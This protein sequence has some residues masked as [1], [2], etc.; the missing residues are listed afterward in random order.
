MSCYRCV[1]YK[2]NFA[3]IVSISA[4]MRS[5]VWLKFRYICK[6]RLLC[7]TH[8]AIHLEVPEYLVKSIIIQSYNISSRKFYIMKLVQRSIY[9]V[10]S[11]STVLVVAS[12]IC[13]SLPYDIR[14]TTSLSLF[15]R[16]LYVNF[17]SL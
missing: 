6:H 12:K 11:K 8:K 3:S 9:L 7:I 5:I 1:L 17:K 13:N 16:K 14:C 4:L 15:K 10:Y 2:L